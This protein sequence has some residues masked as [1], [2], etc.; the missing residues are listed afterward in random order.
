MNLRSLLPSAQ[1]AVLAASIALSAGLVFAADYIT[2][3]PTSERVQIQTGGVAAENSN[4]QAALAEVQRESGIAL[5]PLPD[6]NIF[7]ALRSSA[8]GENLTDTVG[9]T[10]L[11]SLIEA[12]AQG[13]GSDIPTQERLAAQAAAHLEEGS[14]KTSLYNAARLTIVGDSA[15]TL[16]KFGNDVMQTLNDHMDANAGDTLRAIGYAT[17]YNDATY[18]EKL[19]AAEQAYRALAEDLFAVPVPQ[20]LSPLYLQ[21][22]NNFLRIA[23]TYPDMKTILSDPLRGLAG[24]QRFQSLIDETTRVFTTIAEQLQRNAI[25]FTE[26]EPGK[27]WSLLVANPL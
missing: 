8:A 14:T 16:H 9:R 20:T 10:L 3:K 5:P 19:P 4:W 22:V 6:E 18:L 2:Q 12:N 23:D 21:I 26:D 1:F 17:D 7:E 27:T 11:V 24:I 15:T 25:L 13:L